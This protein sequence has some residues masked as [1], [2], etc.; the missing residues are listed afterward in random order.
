[1]VYVIE[2]HLVNA[3]GFVYLSIMQIGTL[4]CEREV[5]FFFFFHYGK[6]SPA[7]RRDTLKKLQ[8]NFK[9]QEMNLT[10]DSVHC[11]LWK[12]MERMKTELNSS[13]KQKEW[14]G[15]KMYYNEHRE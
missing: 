5:V 8:H 7:N 2:A 3:K 4:G 11:L 12:E 10:V 13:E 15:W 14:K 9:W 1:M 6:Y